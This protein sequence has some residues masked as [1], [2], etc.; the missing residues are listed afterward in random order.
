[1]IE[2][3]DGGLTGIEAV[4]HEDPADLRREVSRGSMAPKVA[5]HK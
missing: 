4:I 2:Q 3:T 5:L 1:M